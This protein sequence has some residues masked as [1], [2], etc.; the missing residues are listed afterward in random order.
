MNKNKTDQL[1]EKIDKRLDSIEERMV[2]KT[3]LKNELSNYATKKDLKEMASKKDLDRFATKKDL[4]LMASKKDLESMATKKDLK[5]IAT[6]KNLKKMEV[7][8]IKKI[9]FVIDHFDGENT[10]IKQRLDKV[11][12]RVDLYA[13]SI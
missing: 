9:N 3:D 6:K 2:T 13:S 1:L 8:I 4:E 7:R 12:K 10:E 11:E 5:S